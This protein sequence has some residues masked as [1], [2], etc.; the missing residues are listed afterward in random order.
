MKRTAVL[1]LL[2]ITVF[3]PSCSSVDPEQTITASVE[4]R[5]D[6]AAGSCPYLTKDNKGNIVLSWIKKVDS[7]TTSVCYTVSHDEGKTFGTPIDIPG[8]GNVHPHGENMPKIVFKPSGEIVAVWGASNPNPANAY[9]GLV[10]YTRSDDQGKT[11][12]RPESLTKD[13]SSH[14]QRYFD[15]AL[16]SDGEIGVVWLDNRKRWNNEGSGLYYAVTKGATGF[17]DEKLI[18]GPCCQCCRTD[19]FIDRNTNIHVLYRAIINDS[20]RDMVHITSTDAG[21]NFSKPARISKDNWVINGCPHTGPAMTENKTGLHFT[22]YTGGSD[23][24][25]YFNSSGNNGQSFSTRDSVSG[26]AAKHCQIASLPGGNIMITWNESFV[27]GSTVSSRIG[28]EERNENG[29]RISKRYIT[30][31]NSN[32]SF[33]AIFPINAKKAVVAYTENTGGKEHVLYK[34]VNMQ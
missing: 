1:I 5:V 12:T 21:R 4:T 23:A 27:Q 7:A 3:G 9:S 28:I 22:W 10:F 18:S 17:Q 11:W 15:V 31:D 24:G 19:L 26:K 33:P 2:A 14:D 20:I 13:T 30:S 29:K 25:I 34:L 32:A 16:L 6:T 8:T